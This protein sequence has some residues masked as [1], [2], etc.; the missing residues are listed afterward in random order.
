MKLPA[1]PSIN[2]LLGT[3]LTIAIIFA[4]IRLLPIPE[5]VKSWFRV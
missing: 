1:L 4:A 2:Q 3:A 5:S